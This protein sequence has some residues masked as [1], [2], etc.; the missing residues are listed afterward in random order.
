VVG[1]VAATAVVAWW[2]A[3]HRLVAG[4]GS[5]HDAALAGAED[6]VRAELGGAATPAPP[7]VP[8]R[9]VADDAVWADL[10]VGPGGLP[11]AQVT[12]VAALGLPDDV[13]PAQPA[14]EDHQ[15]VVATA[16]VRAAAPDALLR[17]A[18]PLA[19][20]GS[21]ADRVEVLRAGPRPD[22]PHDVA[23]AT[24]QGT[25]LAAN[26]AL[27]AS[28][29]AAAELAAGQVDTRLMTTLVALAAAGPVELRDL[30]A[31]P[32]EQAAGLPRRVAELGFGS[33]EEARSAA[34]LLRAQQPPYL[35][36][37]VELDADAARVTMTYL[38]APLA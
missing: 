26:P 33:P 7:A 31:P 15:V 10:V 21:G 16:A 1:A 11:A 4:E 2:G 8:V 17:D 28:P 37:R 14:W 38:P 24:V 19:V 32:A 23:A 36:A 25:A 34:G 29:E 22:V 13:G 9:L 5:T 20:F 35:P 12:S 3:E 30:P 18:V 27:T 6:W